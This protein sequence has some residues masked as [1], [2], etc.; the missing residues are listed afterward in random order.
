[1]GGDSSGIKTNYQFFLLHYH[2]SDSIRLFFQV[3][4]IILCNIEHILR[5]LEDNDK[6][7][8]ILYSNIMFLDFFF[9]FFIC[10]SVASTCTTNNNL[11]T[12]LFVEFCFQPKGIKNLNSSSCTAV[13]K[14]YKC[15]SERRSQNG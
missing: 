2:Y 14:C 1:M 7:E 11:G 5:K 3:F 15:M 8:I 4:I 10:F 12:T 13:S 6:S 9:F